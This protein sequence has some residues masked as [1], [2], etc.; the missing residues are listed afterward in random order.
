MHWLLYPFGAL[1]ALILLL[2]G[3]ALW[4]AK[5]AIGRRAPED[6][7][8]AAQTNAVGPRLYYFYAPTCGPC[9]AMTPLVDRLI[10]AHGNLIKVNV[11]QAPELARGFGISATPSFVL[12]EDGIIRQVRLGAQSERQVRALLGMR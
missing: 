5:Q 4:R 11:A 1:I 10:A 6:D 8:I 9:K 2:Q 12:V 3:M 7:A